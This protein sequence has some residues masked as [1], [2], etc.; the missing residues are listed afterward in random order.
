[1]LQVVVVIGKE[2]DLCLCEFNMILLL[3][4]RCITTTIAETTDA[5]VLFCLVTTVHK[6]QDGRE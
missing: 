3:F 4:C 2:T 1:M 6:C 5:F